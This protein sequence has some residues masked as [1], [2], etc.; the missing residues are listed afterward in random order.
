MRIRSDLSP[1]PTR[2]RLFS[3]CSFC[4]WLRS[5]SNN[6]ACNKDIARALFLCCERS[7]WHSTTVLVGRCVI[8]MAESVLFTC[9]PPA[10]EARNVSILKSDV[11]MI[12]SF[13]SSA[14]GSTATVHAE[15]CIRP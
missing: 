4:C 13:T 10:P 2:S 15:V 7:S 6:L 3:A 8:L 1:L 14:S 5:V 9:C 11:F 12:T